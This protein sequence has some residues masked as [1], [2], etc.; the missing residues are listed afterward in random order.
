MTASALQMAESI[1]ST[2]IV[3]PTN[4]KIFYYLTLYRKFVYPDL[5]I[6]FVIVYVFQGECVCW[7]RGGISASFSLPVSPI[8]IR[9]KLVMSHCYQSVLHSLNLCRLRKRLK[10]VDTMFY[11]IIP[12]PVVW[13]FMFVNLI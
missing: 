10:T 6:L 4:F 12:I 7:G 3:W 5:E 9:L 11:I 8:L 1:I 2:E 13:Y